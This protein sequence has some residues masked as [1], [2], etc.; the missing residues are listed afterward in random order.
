[1][2]APPML[3]RILIGAALCMALAAAAFFS[4]PEDL[5]AVALGQ[6]GLY[7]LEVTLGVFYGLLLLVTPAYS[8]LV[9]GRLP[10][11]IST[12]GAK[13]SAEA[14]RSADVNRSRIEALIRTATDLTEALSAAEFEIEQLQKASPRDSTERKVD[15]EP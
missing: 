14:D 12:R 3:V 7:R 15:S 8:G 11:E 4:L 13:F 9:A 5:P 2:F 6:V 1:M 10:I